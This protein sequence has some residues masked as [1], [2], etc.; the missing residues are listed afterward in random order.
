MRVTPHTLPVFIGLLALL[1]ALP[2]SLLSLKTKQD[3]R[4]RAAE[5]TFKIDEKAPYKKGEVIIKYK[6]D[7]KIKTSSDINQHKHSFEVNDIK[8]GMPGTTKNNLVAVGVR[9][10][11]LVFDNAKLPSEQS[12]ASQ[13]L[14]MLGI[15]YKYDPLGTTYRL[16]VSQSQDIKKIIDILGKDPNVEFVE[17][18]YIFQTAVV[19]NDPSYPQTWGMPKINA[20]GAWDITTGSSN[21]VVADIDTGVDLN[22]P[23]LQGNLISGKNFVTPGAQPQDDHGHGTHAA[24]TIGA[25]GNNSVGIAGVDWSVHIMPLKVLGTDGRG[26]EAVISDAIHYA[27]DNGVRV[28][29][30]SLT[31]NSVV[32]PQTLKEAV[33]Y[34]VSKNVIVVAAAGNDGQDVSNYYPAA[35]PQVISVAATTQQDTRA[36]FSNFGDKIVI[37]APGE[38][39]YS[40]MWSGTQIAPC[41]G[42]AYC[43]L[44]GTSMAAPH[45]SGLIALMLAK[46]SSLTPTQVVSFLTS[47][48]DD[49]GPFGRD[50]QFGYGRINAQKALQAVAGGSLPPSPTTSP[51]GSPTT[52]PTTSPTAP[53]SG[54]ATTPEN[55][56]NKIAQACGGNPILTKRMSQTASA[57]DWASFVANYGGL[58]FNPVGELFIFIDR[59]SACT[60]QLQS[61]TLNLNP[62]WNKVNVTSAAGGA[63]VSFSQFEAPKKKKGIMDLLF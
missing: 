36:N 18:N 61:Q 40:T 56:A 57:N 26:T 55:L 17:P 43:S 48:A 7:M 30:M 32:E 24:G 62:G 47:T 4:K 50:P 39:I 25:I 2:A 41:L 52:S 51:T 53:P 28:I 38:G 23:D 3:L 46:N 22:H 45:V 42:Q 58:T 34:A 27:A 12:K 21:I 37:S 8:E 20:P 59:T 15:S 44:S 33:Q 9:K 29:N 49:L 31:M 10:M 60:V 14:T 5:R 13:I 54:G 16:E 1:L 6:T 19:P 35:F 11:D 63:G